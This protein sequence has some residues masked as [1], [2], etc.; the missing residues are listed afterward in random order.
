VDEDGYIYMRFYTTRSTG[1]IVRI[2][3]TSP[4]E[5]DPAP[6][7]YPTATVSVTCNG[8]KTASGQPYIIRVAAE[9]DLN[10]V[11][12]ETWHQTPAETHAVTLPDGTYTLQG[13]EETVLIKVE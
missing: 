10:L 12:I 6:E 1:G 13:A 9:Q 2:S 7:Q 5:T 4:E 3:T 8:N 11:G